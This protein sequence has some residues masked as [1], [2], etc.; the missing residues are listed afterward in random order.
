M[1][2][3]LCSGREDHE[4]P[5]T[6]HCSLTALVKGKPNQGVGGWWCPAG[7]EGLRLSPLTATI[8]QRENGC[9]AV[10]RDQL[11]VQLVTNAAS[12]TVV[13]AAVVVVVVIVVKI[14]K[15]KHH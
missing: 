1:V 8:V 10:P 9:G 3:K 6:K 4:T 11:V 12:A 15:H 7:S 5:S 13:V 14:G 2:G